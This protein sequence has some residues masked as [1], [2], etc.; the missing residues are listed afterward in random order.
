MKKID[1]DLLKDASNRL[2]FT[3][4]DTEYDLLLDEFNI[5][6]KQFELMNNID[7]LEDVEL[8]TFPYLLFNSYLREDIP[9]EVITKEEALKNAHEVKDGQIKLPKVI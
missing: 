2:L 1:K 6:I 9:N 7:N 5:L 4:S 3:M 8:M